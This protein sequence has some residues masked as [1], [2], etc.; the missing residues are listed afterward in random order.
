[1][2]RR[3]ECDADPEAALGATITVP[4]WEAPVSLKIPPATR[5][6]KTFRVRGRGLTT[7]A[8]AGDLLVTVEIAVQK[9]LTDDQR[10]AVEAL[11]E[12]FPESPREYLGV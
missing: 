9:D 3:G 6:G 5:T 11:A 2:S 1:M 12:A 8:G 7:P 4:A 10:K